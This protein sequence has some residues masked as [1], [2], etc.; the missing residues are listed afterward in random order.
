MNGMFKEELEVIGILLIRPM[1]PKGPVRSVG[2]RGWM[3][4]ERKSE[5]W[6]YGTI[7]GWETHG[8]LRLAFTKAN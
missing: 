4:G 2:G 3:E 6:I 7:W 5:Y 8:C 1:A